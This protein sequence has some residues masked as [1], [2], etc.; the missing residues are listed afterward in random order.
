[1]T[2]IEATAQ[3]VRKPRHVAVALGCACVGLVGASIFVQHVLGIEP[4][5]LC[6]LQRFT[7][8]GLIPIFFGAALAPVR[9]R[10]G[11]FWAAGILSLAG[12]AVAGYQTEL[13]LFPA[14]VTASCSASLAY[15]LDTMAVTDVLVALLHAGGDCADTSFKV[16]GLTLAQASTI[17]FAS[18]VGLIA[19]VLLQI[20]TVA[21][22]P[23]SL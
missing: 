10:R 7:Y 14:A 13:Q 19:H 22:R 2:L 6:I 4:C 12:L 9:I 17:I 23:A 5:P 8:L 16:L 20:R 18:F 15:M 1:M 21:S 3:F 11:L